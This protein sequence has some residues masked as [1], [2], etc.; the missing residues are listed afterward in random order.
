MTDSTAF[1]AA[2]ENGTVGALERDSRVLAFAPVAQTDWVVTVSLP[3]SE[4]YAIGRSVGRNVLG[5]VLGSILVLGVVATALGRQTVVPLTRLR[6]RAEQ[7]QAGDLDVELST[8]R[9]DEIG[10]LFESFDGMRT[11]LR[12]QFAETEAALEDAQ[13]ARSDAESA[14]AEA[15]AARDRA[16]ELS[17]QLQQQATAYGETMRACA[18]GELHR[19]LDEDVDSEAMVEIAAAFNEM[20]DDLSGRSRRSTGSPTTWR[21]RAS[22]WSSRP[23]T[24]RT[25]ASRSRIGSAVSPPGRATRA[26]ASTTWPRRPRPC[27][28]TSRRSPRTPARSPTPHSTPSSAGPRA[29]RPPRRPSTRWSNS[30]PRPARRSS[31]WT[32]WTNRSGLSVTWPT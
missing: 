14:Q 32:T 30:R 25:A 29:A 12:E 1:T 18:D 16:R 17:D 24:W 8:R 15:E 2:A 19:R 9:A 27:R 4:A 10:R 13:A 31:R 28:Q 26:S 20:M 11:S 21:P 5:I 6:R 23:P 22:T 7:M 3:T